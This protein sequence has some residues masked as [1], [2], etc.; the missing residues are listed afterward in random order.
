MEALKTYVKNVKSQPYMPN[1]I[2]KIW[3]L[4]IFI[5]TIQKNMIFALL[6]V[7]ILVKI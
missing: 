7:L 3:K 6:I 1:S 2:Y 4:S 5:D